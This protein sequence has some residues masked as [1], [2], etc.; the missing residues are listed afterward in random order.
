M[1]RRPGTLRSHHTCPATLCSTVHARFAETVPRAENPNHTRGAAHDSRGRLSSLCSLPGGTLQ[2][3]F[4]TQQPAQPP[5]VERATQALRGEHGASTSAVARLGQGHGVRSVRGPPR[6][7]SLSRLGRVRLQQEQEQAPPRK[8]YAREGTPPRSRPVTAHPHA[9][10]PEQRLPAPPGERNRR[11]VLHEAHKAQPAPPSP[12][13]SSTRRGYVRG[14]EAEGQANNDHKSPSGDGG[15][16][17]DDAAEAI[18]A[19]VRRLLSGRQQFNNTALMAANAST[20]GAAV[21]V[22]VAGE[23]R[24]AVGCRPP[25]ASTTAVRYA[26]QA[27]PLLPNPAAV[28]IEIASAAS[29]ADAPRNPL[30]S[31]EAEL[32]WINTLV[33]YT[34]QQPVNPHTRVPINLGSRQ[35]QSC[36]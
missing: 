21:A 10:R 17:A 8:P 6:S 32:S 15:A 27:P 9:R 13:A 23:Q 26:T 19:R 36:T 5:A 2:G 14:A 33:Q 18:T 11:L 16:D 24:R 12:R 22:A 25:T 4:R 30:P 7:V 34:R 29:R 35:S 28:G 1:P 31:D 3:G 20:A